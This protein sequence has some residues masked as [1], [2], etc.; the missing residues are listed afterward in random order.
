MLLQ[1]VSIAS[2]EPTLSV[3]IPTL[4][5]EAVLCNT[6]RTLLAR[7]AD[8]PFE[9]IIIDQSD[10]HEESTS[11]YLESL[12]DRVIHRRASY[13]N[14]PRARNEGLSLAS[15][16][17]VVFIDDDV[18]VHPGFLSGHLAPYA[19]SKVWMV[20]GPSPKPGEPILARREISDDDYE[21]L[22][23]DDKILLQ[24]DFDHAPCS[25]APGCNFSIRRHVAGAV[26][27]FD[28][29][30][31]GNAIGEDA[32]FCHRIKQHG[33]TIYYAGR[34]ALTHLVTPDGGCRSDVGANYVRMFAYNQNYFR[35]AI[36]RTWPSM[37]EWNLRSYRQFVLNKANILKA[38]MHLSFLVGLYLGQRQPLTKYKSA[39]PADVDFEGPPGKR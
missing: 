10:S 23:V 16:E 18:E 3:V 38:R 9:L 7:E 21:R 31:K 15:G 26:G 30:F 37:L 6:I 25:W 17:I 33:G 32:E 34:A 28:E 22:F 39:R 11:R 27:G 36:G 1:D 12:A 19:D 8:R 29:N 4:N 13:K 14:L 24:V 20:T 5:R 35:R 2:P